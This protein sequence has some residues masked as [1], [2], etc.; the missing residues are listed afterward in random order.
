MT[1]R[2]IAR[3][4]KISKSSAHRFLRGVREN[5]KST[6]EKLKMSSKPG[7]KPKINARDKRLLLRTLKRVR[8]KNAN[9]TVMSL[10][11]EADLDP[12]L[13]HRRT[14][15]KYLNEMGFHFL[16]ARK[17]GCCPKKTDGPV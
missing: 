5:S 6:Q 1:V 4:C 15:T 17:K 9:I 12:L 16:Q 11:Q 7:P 14:Y 13:V 2:E 8:E 3:E 10:V